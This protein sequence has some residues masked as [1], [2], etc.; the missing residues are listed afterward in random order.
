MALISMAVWDTDENKRSELTR[1]CLLSLLQTV[2]FSKHQLFISDNGSC[3]ETQK[4]YSEFKECFDSHYYPNNL[5]SLTI[6]RNYKNLGTAEAVNIGWAGRMNG[7]NCIKMDNDC[8]IHQAG[9]VDE[10]EEAIAREPKIGILGLKRVD[11]E[12]SPLNPHPFYHSELVMLPH[13]PGQKWIVVEKVKH[14]IGTCQMYSSALLDKIGYLCQPDLY[15]FD[16]SLAAVRCNVAG[17]DNYFLPHISISH[18]D[19]GAHDYQAWKQQHA[20]KL[21]TA[22]N[23]AVAD[24]RSGAKSVYHNPFKK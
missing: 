15:G 5:T 6:H 8:I 2:D 21:F 1:K 9:W 17:F 24:Y 22:Y 14:V 20:G 12:E 13:I 18:L 23:Q 10:M 19:N 4:V 3:A 16:D 11:I 7:E